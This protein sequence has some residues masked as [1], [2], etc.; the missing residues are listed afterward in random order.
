MRRSLASATLSWPL[1]ILGTLTLLPLRADAARFVLTWDKIRASDAP[2]ILAEVVAATDVSRSAPGARAE[3][4]QGY[5]ITLKIHEVL[6]GALAAERIEIP[7]S[8]K[9]YSRVWEYDAKPQ[10]GMKVLVFLASGAGDQWND[11]G[12]PGTIEVIKAFDSPRVK[13]LQKVLALWAI[14]SETD[15]EKALRAGCLDADLGFRLYCA[16]VLRDRAFRRGPEMRETLSFLWELYT[17]D[18]V[19]LDTWQVCDNTFWNIFRTW[20]WQNFEPRYAI[21]CKVVARTW[22]DEDQCPTQTLNWVL[23]A[24]TGYGNHRGETL[25]LLST[26][27]NGDRKDVG[28]AA[29]YAWRLYEFFPATADE[30]A[31]NKKLLAALSDW[32][33][34]G[35]PWAAEGAATGIDQLVRESLRIGVARPDVAELVRT[36]AAPKDDK[37]A[38]ERLASSRRVLADGLPRLKPFVEEEG[39]PI[40]QLDLAAHLGREVRM[41]GSA[42]YEAAPA[43][44]VAISV[45]GRLVWLPAVSKWPDGSPPRNDVLARGELDQANDIPVFRYEKGQPF[46]EGLPVPEGYDLKEVSRRYF[47]R[48]A[49]WKLIG[50]P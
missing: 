18:R 2:I 25:A 21:A 20:G 47:L 48:D 13:T 17:D 28:S 32:V 31:M 36:A 11:F 33:N 8:P 9:G 5:R 16:G 40:I 43:W 41:V 45:D 24:L 4:E 49:T 15:R 39:P 22:R 1:V 26:I 38:A 12:L 50:N 34:R 46:G 37:E 14:K 42:A 3:E 7:F 27:A 44:G 19:D 29:L 23:L 10:K 6:R 35:K 30:R